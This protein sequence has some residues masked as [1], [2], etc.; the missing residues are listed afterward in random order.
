M[1]GPRPEL[2]AG[3]R[4]RLEAAIDGRELVEL[5][6]QLIRARTVNPPGEEYRAAEVAAAWLE[7]QGFRLERVEARPGRTN[8][9]AALDGPE[10]GPALLWCGHLD[11]VP[12]GEEGAW[13]RPPFAGEV[14]S[15]RLYGRGAVDMKGPIAAALVAAAALRRCGGPRR[16]R[17]LFALVADEEAIG[18]LGAGFL[19]KDGRLRADGAILGE[20][21]RLHLV[22]AQRGAVWARIRL[23]GRA[24][25]A[26]APH[27]G[28]SAIVAAARLVLAL[29]ER[30]WDAFH[31]L[32]GP[33]TASVGSI[34]GGD[35]VNRVAEWCELEVDRRTVPGET[36]A[37][38]RG[39]LEEVLRSVCQR[40][41]GIRAEITGWR[42][43]APA[44]TA[45]EAAVVQLV[46]A[47]ARLALGREPD[48]AG[49][50]AV[51]DMRFL[52]NDAGIPTVLFG[53]GRPD[54]AHAPDEWVE[55]ADLER[56]ALVYALA[57]AGWLGA[58][59]DG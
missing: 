15:G 47:A 31:P 57:F 49:T 59:G 17:L 53:P 58:G 26:A 13:T 7:R 40:Q 16:G 32:L 41:P 21:T 24:A 3:L 2:D 23:H 48:E 56:A 27:R 29:E 8:L 12:A 11:V 55:V 6:R 20:P 9:L 28:S 52:V 37:A 45:E 22:R 10:P 14:E 42:A 19:V 39:E 46:R 43:A 25:H 5:A 44:E 34:R 50:V 38:V 51:T 33:P 54:L 36:E 35:R 18:E 1:E 30:V 4:R